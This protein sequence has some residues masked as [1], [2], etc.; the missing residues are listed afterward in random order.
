MIK[1]KS[2]MTSITFRKKSVEEIIS[3]AKQ[4]NLKG[5]EWGGDVH[6]PVG[7]TENAKKVGRLTREAGLEVFSYGA[8]LKV[9]EEGFA[10]VAR[11]AVALGCKTVRIWPPKPA[12]SEAGDGDYE[13][14]IAAL[15]DISETARS[16]GL[17]I[18]LEWHNGRLNDCAESSLRILKGVN[19]ENIRT[20][21][22]PIHT[23]ANNIRY[24][25]SMEGVIENVH[26]YNW[27]YGNPII[28]LPLSANRE[29]WEKYIDTLGY[30]NYIL[31]FTADDSDEN[32]LADARTLKELL[33]ETG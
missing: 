3:I 14:A 22:Q 18:C 28:R 5:I 6:V 24:I 19:R 12:S 8:Y 1:G 9:G 27:I 31:E 26:V 33:H 32:F 11:T 16:H 17:T 23:Y 2:G 15:K 13:K 10:D 29:E 4:A 20:Y 30:R 21:W 25:Q 7:D